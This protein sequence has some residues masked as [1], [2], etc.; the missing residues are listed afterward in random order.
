MS[1]TTLGVDVSRHYANGF[2]R[3]LERLYDKEESRYEHRPEWAQ[4]MEQD[5]NDAVACSKAF[6][7]QFG[8][9]SPPNFDTEGDELTHEVTDRR[10][11]EL[12]RQLH[13]LETELFGDQGRQQTA[14]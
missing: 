10:L 3:D 14:R 11:G 2:E 8:P 13:E 1:P 6:V 5:I 7:G 4:R 9:T 12:E